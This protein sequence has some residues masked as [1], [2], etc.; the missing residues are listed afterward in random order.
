MLKEIHKKAIQV[1][2]TFTVQ[3][4]YTQ[5]LTPVRSSGDS[6]ASSE[7]RQHL[8]IWPVQLLLWNN[9][10]PDCSALVYCVLKFHQWKHQPATSTPLRTQS[11]CFHTAHPWPMLHCAVQRLCIM[12]V[13]HLYARAHDFVATLSMLKWSKLEHV[14][15]TCSFQT[16]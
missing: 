4:K 11:I 16:L 3:P 10:H 8:I 9:S 13:C 2:W 5:L 15:H 1:Y 12:C 7:R 6:L 14:V